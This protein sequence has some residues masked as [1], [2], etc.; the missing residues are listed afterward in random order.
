M[1]DNREK[2]M[3]NSGG[4]SN[5]SIALHKHVFTEKIS[6][7]WR[8]SPLALSSSNWRHHV[9]GEP[10]GLR[11]DPGSAEVVL[12]VYCERGEDVIRARD[13]VNLLDRF[14]LHS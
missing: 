7:E 10:V 3:I 13:K 11:F 1:S 4:Q 5:A 14:G 6:G 12:E 8:Q 2:T 9:N